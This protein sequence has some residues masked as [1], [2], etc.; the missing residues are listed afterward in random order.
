MTAS[1]EPSSAPGLPSAGLTLPALEARI[2]A[3][4]PGALFVEEHLL[5]RVVR[6]A[7]GSKRVRSHVPHTHVFAAPVD[8]VRA[9]LS[10]EELAQCQGAAL[11]ATG[12]AILLPRPSEDELAERAA[13]EHLVAAWRAVF[14]ARI[15]A[16]LYDL[17]A[18]GELPRELIL[19]AIATI[20]HVAMGEARGV[21]HD[22]GLTAAAPGDRTAIIELTSLY[23]ELRY[24]APRLIP[25]WFPA[26]AERDEI[27]KLFDRLVAAEPILRATRPEG[28]PD[29]SRVG[30]EPEAAEDPDDAKGASVPREA[31]RGRAR[32]QLGMARR[33]RARANDAG[34]AIH[35]HFAAHLAARSGQVDAME[36]AEQ[37]RR[38]LNESLASMGQRLTRIAPGVAHDAWPEVLTPLLRPASLGM[39]RVEARLLHDLQKACHVAEHETWDIDLGRW[40]R[41]L[42]R[43]PI[44]RRET[45]ASRVAV[46]RNL[47]RAAR[48][49]AACRLADADRRRLRRTMGELVHAAEARLREDIGAIL[50]RGLEEAGFR[51]QNIPEQVASEKLVAELLD[52]M[53]DRGFVAFPDLRDLIARNQ[54]KLGDLT[55]AREFLRGDA[56]LQLNR[57]FAETLDGAYHRAEIY[58]RGLQ[59]VQ[60]T[61]F[62]NPIGRVLVRYLL[63]PFG[64][65]FFLVQGL[66]HVVGPLLNLILPRD[67][68]AEATRAV[69]KSYL[70][71]DPSACPQQHIEFWSIPFFITVGVLLLG[72]LHS[73]HVRLGMELLLRWLGRAVT[74]LVVDVP[75]AILAWPPVAALTRHRI[76][77]W[78]REKL[79]RP[80]AWALILAALPMPWIGVAHGLLWVGLPLFIIF[81]ALLIGPAG[82]RI[83][84]TVQDRASV[85]W[86]VLRTNAIPA[87]L[88]AIASFFKGMV[89]WLEARL[90]AV[91]QWLRF[92]EGDSRIG[93]GVKALFGLMWGM[94]AYLLRFM[95]NLVAEPQLNPIKHFPV[96]TVS[97]KIFLTTT[98]EMQHA[99]EPAVGGVAAAFIAGLAQLVLPGICGFLVWEFKENWRLYAANRDAILKPAMVG[100]H[101]ETIVRLIRPGFH[102]G[103]VPKLFHKIRRA[104][105]RRDESDLRRLAEDAHHIEEATRNF[106]IRE[107]KAL[108]VASGR[109]PHAAALRV[110]DVRLSPSRLLVVVACAPIGH[111]PFELAFEEQGRFIVATVVR[112]GFVAALPEVEAS[113]EGPRAAFAAALRGLYA[114]AGVDLVREQIEA[115]FSAWPRMPPYGIERRGLVLWPN[116]FR[117]EVRFGLRTRRPL[118]LPVV[119]GPAPTPVPPPVIAR[120]A[121][122]FKQ[123]PIAWRDWVRAWNG[124][125]PASLGGMDLLAKVRTG[126]QPA[127]AAATVVVAPATRA[128]APVEVAAD[129]AG[130]SHI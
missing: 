30:A 38:L 40:V 129:V 58:R 3:V 70:G 49:V 15:D 95:I 72:V 61:L 23:Q 81:G 124:A 46:V 37:A 117:T 103:T 99:L 32:R 82:D 60:S 6:D 78:I 104:E 27:P 11:P 73:R 107:L 34:A 12:W 10:A 4:E 111:E 59:R 71:A 19:E 68:L 109:F 54:L 50:A 48:R 130:G 21:L 17:D 41:R 66:E 24:F 113:G 106:V 7:L 29:P 53:V 125:G 127:P 101:G 47:A 121:I 88:G 75:R 112:A 128:G 100:S 18:R 63:L 44:R 115:Q 79:W 62:A 5:R 92:R 110:H 2:R 22:E 105:R 20:G 14:H 28:A 96:V 26:L 56:L 74:A 87:L 123:Q 35:A 97:H 31:V 114:L 33:M 52:L 51:P 98:I 94:I 80:A 102:A 43:D 122:A 67:P 108:L 93:L 42:G 126:V 36:E 120:A 91:D 55:N 85:G 69:C 84:E 90:Y 9:L 118:L 1:H 57:R 89:E 77:R 16:A 119:V 64:G 13:G 45:V 39:V 8:R 25:R 83:S 65:S 76:Y 86:F 116:A